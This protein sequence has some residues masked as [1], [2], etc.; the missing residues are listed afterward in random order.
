VAKSTS[1]AEMSRRNNEIH[2]EFSFSIAKNYWR[3]EAA[4]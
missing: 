4:L 1:K 2:S 3:L